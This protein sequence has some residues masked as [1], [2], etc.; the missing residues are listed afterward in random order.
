LLGSGYFGIRKHFF[1]ILVLAACTSI[2]TPM[3]L[4]L[5]T[6]LAPH[7]LQDELAF[8]GHQVHEAAGNLGS[9]R[10]KESLAAAKTKKWKSINSL[11]PI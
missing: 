7:P 1:L 8:H 9:P 4:I 3:I 2:E 5:F 10:S 6:T 11:Y